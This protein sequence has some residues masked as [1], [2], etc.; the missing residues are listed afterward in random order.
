MII[1]A[2]VIVLALAL[3]SCSNEIS[4]DVAYCEPDG[5]G[6]RI[7]ETHTGSPRPAFRM[8]KAYPRDDGSLVGSAIYVVVERDS[9]HVGEFRFEPKKGRCVITLYIDGKPTTYRIKN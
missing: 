4:M 7:I 3:T 8:G 2:A 9:D 6:A 5:M 1:Y